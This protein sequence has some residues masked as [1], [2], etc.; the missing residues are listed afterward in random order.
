MPCNPSIHPIQSSASV[1]NDK[2]PLHFACERKHIQV[3]LRLLAHNANP[4]ARTKTGR[5]PLHAAVDHDEPPLAI[6]SELLHRNANL[7]ARDK[8]GDTPLHLLFRKKKELMVAE[9]EEGPAVEEWTAGDGAES[10]SMGAVEETINLILSISIGKGGTERARRILNLKNHA[11]QVPYGPEDKRMHF[12]QH[13]RELLAIV[14]REEEEDF[15][16]ITDLDLDQDGVGR[17]G[18]GRDGVEQDE[19]GDVDGGPLGSTADQ[20]ASDD[21]LEDVLIQQ[22]VDLQWEEKCRH[23]QKRELCWYLL[24]LLLFTMVTVLR[25]GYGGEQFVV[26]AGLRRMFLEVTYGATGRGGGNFEG[27]YHSFEH[28]HS[29]G[30]VLEYVEGVIVEIGSVSQSVIQSVRKSVRKS[31]RDCQ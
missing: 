10:T 11:G 23:R 17:D 30:E 7:V 13:E 3:V 19:D 31:V 21:L 16:A 12:K 2:T 18:V 25:T 20:N 8:A 28:L 15:G 6:V 26:N 4:N 29:V 9:H 14:K 22:A 24:V 27:E 5:T 1:Q